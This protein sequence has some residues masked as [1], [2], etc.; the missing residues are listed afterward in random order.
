MLVNRAVN[1][2]AAALD[3][4]VSLLREPLPGSI[5]AN[6]HVVAER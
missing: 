3:A 2:L 6:Y 1:G 4:R 5:F